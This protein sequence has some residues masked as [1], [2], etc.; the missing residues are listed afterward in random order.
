MHLGIYSYCFNL[1]IWATLVG[2][3][4][5]PFRALLCI[6]P[7]EHGDR[8][9]THTSNSD[10]QFTTAIL[11]GR[12]RIRAPEDHLLKTAYIEM[13]ELGADSNIGSAP[14]PPLHSAN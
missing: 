12:N 10:F 2:A 3:A 1:G 6:W 7:S 13:Y 5:Q 4:L 9:A 11:K 14:P 8:L